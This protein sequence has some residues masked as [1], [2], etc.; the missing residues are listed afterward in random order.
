MK[1]YHYFI[2]FFLI[3]AGI[4]GGFWAGLRYSHVSTGDLVSRPHLSDKPADPSVSL[5]PQI[6]EKVRETAL[7]DDAGKLP[8]EFGV[9]ILI[10]DKSLQLLKEEYLEKPDTAKL[11]NGAVSGLKKRLKSR[12]LDASFVMLPPKD[13]SEKERMKILHQYYYKSMSLYGKKI[14]ESYIAYGALSGMISTLG[15]PYSLVMEPQEYKML[16]EY[17]TGGN[18]GGIGI[19]LEKNRQSNLLHVVDTVLGG[20]AEKTGIKSGD[21]IAKINGESVKGMDLDIASG[22]IRGKKGTRITLLVDSPKTGKKQLQLTRDVIHEKSVIS[23]MKPGG[24]GYIKISLFG[25]STGTEFNT[26]LQKLYSQGAKALLIDFRNNVGGYISGAIDVCSYLLESGSLVVSVVNPRTGR[27]EVYRAYGCAQTKLPIAILVNENSASSSEIAA[28]AFRDTG[29]ALI[30]GDKT[31]GKGIVQSLREFRDGGA[32]KITVAKYLTPKGTDINK[33][34]L[35]PDVVV[36]M[37]PQYVNTPDDIQREKAIE[38]LKKRMKKAAYLP[39]SDC[40]DQYSFFLI[41]A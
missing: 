14:S 38:I 23:A 12:G 39:P 32:L 5:P 41:C 18:Y 40:P 21:I 4:F 35:M 31:Y 2:I 24:I 13:V 30:V 33:K 36:K 19:S 9:D 27:N 26:E 8:A 16:N 20:P 25:E 10:V 22:K 17:M 7:S 3:V 34:G 6:S 28:G 29:S 37:P 1:K 15:D 11:I